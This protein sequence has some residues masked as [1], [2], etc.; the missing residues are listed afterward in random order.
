MLYSLNA[1][2]IL[3]NPESSI[4]E[5]IRS[6]ISEVEEIFLFDNSIKPND[7][8][9]NK[10]NYEDRKKIKYIF[11]SENKGLPK[12]INIAISKSIG[13]GV[14]FLLTMDQDSKF[15]GKDFITFKKMVFK[16][17]YNNEKIGVYA[18]F[19]SLPNETK[20]VFCRDYEY[21]DI[22]MT[23]GN[24]IDNLISKDIG[25]FNEEYFIDGVDWEYCLRLSEHDYKVLRVN[26]VN[27]EH[28][29]GNP[30]L[31][32]DSFIKCNVSLYNYNYIR[33]YYIT[34][35]SLTISFR[36]IFKSPRR[37]LI[38]LLYIPIDICKIIFF[39]SDKN[40]KLKSVYYGILDFIMRRRG[41]TV[42]FVH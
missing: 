5:N 35:N 9:I 42:R 29:L 28:N 40:R 34:R 36:Y 14:R 19:H 20:K 1:V 38:W 12:G 21:T 7:W 30:E 22:V 41:K 17:S 27:L 15:S 37:C 26:N 16:H 2:V 13:K 24:I 11:N 3:Y 6:Y 32:S 4:I 39:E 31:N 23:S 8:I 33:R 18:P 10:F 25:Y